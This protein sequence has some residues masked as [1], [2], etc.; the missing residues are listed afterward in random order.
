MGIFDNILNTKP[1]MA[2]NDFWNAIT[3]T[4]DLQNAISDSY[5]KKIVIFKHS[6][7]C[8]ISKTVLKNFEN[9][10]AQSDKNLGYY[11]LDLLNYR[12]ISNQIAQDFGVEHQSPQIIVLEN[13]KMQ[14]HAS[15]EQ[16][17]HDQI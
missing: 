1:K 4:E 8:F 16:I 7:R 3:S 12:S 2:E 13:G 11:Y 5:N 17:T 15:H 14:H 6:T 9:E 10:V